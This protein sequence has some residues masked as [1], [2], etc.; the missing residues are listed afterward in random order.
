[1]TKP[2]IVGVIPARLGSVRVKSKNLRLLAGKPLI[3]YAIKT[4]QEATVFD[5][6][7]VNSD[8]PLIGEVA[9]RYDI[10]FYQRPKELGTSSASF[11]SLFYDFL[12]NIQCD[13]LAVVC[14]TAPF[15]T[16]TEIDDCVNHFLENNLDTQLACEDIR[17]HC[18]LKGQPVNFSTGGHH[19]RSQDIPTIQALNFA[20][21][22]WRSEKFRQNYEQNGHSVYTGK[23]G[24]YPFEGLSTIDIDWEED[25]ALAELIM[26]NRDRFKNRTPKWDPVVDELIKSGHKT[27]S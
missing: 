26:E 20:V 1:M 11:D 10:P 8:S 9:K 18:F 17:T 14:P 22:I 2:K 5:E 19:P 27:E 21:T 4:L 23:V 15:I 3:Y 6:I 24:F 16:S 7:Y 25:F 13:V 12:N